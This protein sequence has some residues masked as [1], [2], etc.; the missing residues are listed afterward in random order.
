M[1]EQFEYDD[2]TAR[3]AASQFDELGSSLTSLINGLHAE[4]SGDSPWSHDKIG[5]AFASKFDPDRSQVI[6]NAGDYAK[7][8]ESVAPALTDASNSI[9]AQDGGVAG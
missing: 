4:L 7:A 8:V 3:A 6:T 9:I 2:G 5:S 1:A